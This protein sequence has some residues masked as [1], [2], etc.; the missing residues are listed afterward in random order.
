MVLT[1]DQAHTG[2]G[3][4][5]ARPNQ[6]PDRACA[7]DGHLHLL[8]IAS[9]ILQMERL[10]RQRMERLRCHITCYHGCSV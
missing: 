3:F 4:V 10:E 2:P 1:P 6:T 7:V 9:R 5:E 8:V